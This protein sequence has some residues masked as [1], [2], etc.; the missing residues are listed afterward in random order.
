VAPG[1]DKPP[2]GCGVFGPAARGWKRTSGGVRMAG[3]TASL[4]NYGR[5]TLYR[6]A[7]PPHEKA[8][9]DF[10]WLDAATDRLKEVGLD[11]AAEFLR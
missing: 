4:F 3:G 1:H 11:D 7:A 6:S 9:P 2:E 10:D 8:M 5:D